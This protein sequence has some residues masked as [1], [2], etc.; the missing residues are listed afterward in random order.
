ML[1][2]E[3]KPITQ[4]LVLTVPKGSGIPL[5]QIKQGKQWKRCNG[6]Q[7]FCERR[8]WICLLTLWPIPVGLRSPNETLLGNYTGNPVSIEVLVGLLSNTLKV[9]WDHYAQLGGEY[10]DPRWA[11]LG[12]TNAIP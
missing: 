8:G 5:L 11:A 1:S 10:N 4:Q 7:Q 3:M 12:K 9:C 2:E 6:V